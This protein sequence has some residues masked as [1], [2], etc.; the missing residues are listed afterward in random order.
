MS[1]GKI[2]NSDFCTEIFERRN[3]FGNVENPRD[4][5]TH[6]GLIEKLSESLAKHGYT[7]EVFRE[8]HFIVFTKE[9][10]EKLV[11]PDFYTPVYREM[12]EWI[13]RF[14]AKK[15]ANFTGSEDMTRGILFLGESGIDTR[16]FTSEEYKPGLTTEQVTKRA[17]ANH[18]EIIDPFLLFAD[19]IPVYRVIRELNEHLFALK[20]WNI[21]Y[22][23]YYV[24]DKFVNGMF[25]QE[26]KKLKVEH[27]T[28][29]ITSNYL[30]APRTFGFASMDNEMKLEFLT[31]ETSR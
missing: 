5:I 12:V 30:L 16:W 13:F 18:Y 2:A 31:R 10:V 21:D 6:M 1:T 8:P 11:N 15:A 28:T 9:L 23:K 26:D 3:V 22:G 19:A 24:S 27:N 14:V 25:S 29:Q 17:F 20:D 7:Q 4:G